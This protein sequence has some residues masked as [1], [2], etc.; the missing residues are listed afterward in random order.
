MKQ[1]IFSIKIQNVLGGLS[2][3]G[4]LF[5]GKMSFFNVILFIVIQLCYNGLWSFSHQKWSSIEN[6]VRA[7]LG[8]ES[9]LIISDGRQDRIY[10]FHLLSL[11]KLL[12]ALGCGIG[13]C[14]IFC[15]SFSFQDNVR[16]RA[17]SKLEKKR[18][19][20]IGRHTVAEL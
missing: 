5:Q 2:H 12:A 10:Y 13:T 1:G 7:V 16:S 18:N 17:I 3:R 6:S 4:L 14:S 9:S 20:L 15:H 19:L 11:D 8:W